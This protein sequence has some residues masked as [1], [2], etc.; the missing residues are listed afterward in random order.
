MTNNIDP[1]ECDEPFDESDE[2]LTKPVGSSNEEPIHVDDW[3]D[4]NFGKFTYPRWFFF[5][6][7]LASVYQSDWSRQISQYKLFCTYGGKRFRVTG[8]SRMGDVWLSSDFNQ[9]V[10]YE[11][12]VNLN[13]CSE[14]SELPEYD[15]VAPKTSFPDPVMF[16]SLNMEDRARV[17]RDL[18]ILRKNDSKVIVSSEDLA[19]LIY[20]HDDNKKVLDYN[21]DRMKWVQEVFNHKYHQKLPGFPTDTFIGQNYVDTLSSW[22]VNLLKMVGYK[23]VVLKYRNSGIAFWTA[24]GEEHGNEVV[25]YT[26]TEQKARNIVEQLNQSN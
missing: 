25:T 23:F 21:I 12:R 18:Q 22:V 15:A 14:W 17:L 4:S 24:A 7:R 19:G 10:G 11:H 5:L 26:D 9:T 3:I 8:A 6:H 13:D 16:I 1:M 2:P 20:S